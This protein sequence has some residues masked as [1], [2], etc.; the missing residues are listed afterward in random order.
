MAGLAG[1]PVAVVIGDLGRGGAQRVAVNLVNAW[2]GQ[3]RDV[4]VIT[5][6][7]AVVDAFA[8]APTVRRIA[9]D[10]RQPA[11]SALS[12]LGANFGRILALRRAIGT[13]GCPVVVAFVGRTNVLT[14]LATRGLGRRVIISERNDPARQSLGRAWDWLRRLTYP[15]AD[16]VT[17]NSRG[18][19]AALARWVPA[20]RLAL[21]RNPLAPPP[22]D[23]RT[24]FGQP[25]ILHVGRL[26]HQKAQDILL[27]AF[28]AFA[29]AHPDWRLMIVGDG[30]SADDLH[31]L[32]A[33]L[34]IAERV[35]WLPH[36]D[37]PFPHYRG[38]D[39]FVLASRY[40]GTPNA[41]LEAM[42]CGCAAIVSDASQGPLE[43]VEHDVTGLVVPSD[44]PGPL[45]AALAR[46]ADD[47][48]LRARL[49]RAARQR[50][51]DLG[52]DRVVWQWNALLDGA[53][54]SPVGAW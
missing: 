43:Y 38:A 53:A 1:R 51:A 33:Q 47:A 37:D 24:E 14:V 18:A 6:A 42:S 50:V 15:L 34:G 21:V 36:I 30:K 11:R 17:A 5:M 19:L 49:G 8:L 13:S 2:I 54:V 40:E 7:S 27:R 4:C 28:A 44:A 39:M 22:N 12:A 20:D 52:I 31:A 26:S 16:M 35:T 46:L 32:A 48:G 29:A 45:A 10:L 25:T 3:G 41:L 23:D 9:L